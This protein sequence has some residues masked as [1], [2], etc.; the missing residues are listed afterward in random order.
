MADQVVISP[1]NPQVAVDGLTS[2]RFEASGVSRL[3]LL[4][5]QIVTI[6]PT[7]FADGF[8]SGDTTAWSL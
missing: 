3:T 1:E 2:V 7:L 4:D 5:E 8:E 6:D